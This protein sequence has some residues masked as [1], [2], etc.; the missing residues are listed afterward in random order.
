MPDAAAEQ[1]LVSNTV[2]VAMPTLGD[3][4]WVCLRV[5]VLVHIVQ[6]LQNFS[7]YLEVNFH[8]SL[9]SKV[10]AYVVWSVS[11]CLRDAEEWITLIYGEASPLFKTNTTKFH[12]KGIQ[13]SF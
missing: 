9:I 13:S 4:L 7:S 10:F 6:S 2:F 1:T 12:C 8:S 5:C 3:P 11:H